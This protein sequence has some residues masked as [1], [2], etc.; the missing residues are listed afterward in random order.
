MTVEKKDF[1]HEVLLNREKIAKRVKELGG[2]ISHDYKDTK[3]LFVGV[4]KGSFIF[5]ADLLREIDPVLEAQVD[6]MAISS[7]GSG[8]ESSGQPKIEKDL[9]MDIKDRDVILVE[10]IVDTGYSFKTLLAILSS[11]GPSSLKTCALLSKPDRREVEVPVDYL[12][13]VIENKWIEGYGTDTDEEFRGLKDIV[14]R[15]EI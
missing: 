15:K 10:D 2:K 11:R 6:F 1:T 7:Y 12:G 14:Y 8:T 9:S 4:L 5:L 13:F 3:P